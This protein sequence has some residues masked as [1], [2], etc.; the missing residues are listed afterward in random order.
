MS[1]R[2]QNEPCHSL[3]RHGRSTSESKRTRRA[4]GRRFR[5]GPRAASRAATSEQQS[6]A[7]HQHGLAIAGVRR[8]SPARKLG[9]G[10]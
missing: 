10:F 2:G 4:G 1:G 9:G 3:R 6:L 8:S 5:V 7:Y